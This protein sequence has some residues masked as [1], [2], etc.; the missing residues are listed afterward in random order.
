MTPAESLYA[1]V[2]A[3]GE[4][5]RLGTGTRKA[6]L[7]I[8]GLPLAVWSLRAVAAAPGLVGGIVVVHPDDV[9][10]AERWLELASPAGSWEVVVGGATRAES[11]SRGLARI[12]DGVA[13]VLIHDA[14]RPLLHRDDC[15][16]VV[17]AAW[18]CG[19]AILA[20]RVV[21]TVKRVGDDDSIE[22]TVDRSTLWGAETPQVFSRRALVAA[23][24]EL[25]NSEAGE[26]VTDDASWFELTGRRVDVVESRFANLKVTRPQ[27]VDIARVLMRAPPS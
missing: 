9:V 3:A 19:G 16:R 12:P 27:D 22:E 21:D 2:P 4:G 20:H 25:S 8:E 10:L 23:L 1:L 7:E 6:A 14:A 26:R 17:R 15:D 18:R 24:E 13:W 11:V 5:R